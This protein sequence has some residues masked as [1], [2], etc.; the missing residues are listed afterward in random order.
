MLLSDDVDLSY[1]FGAF[2]QR[3]GRRPSYLLDSRKVAGLVRL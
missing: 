3:R 2:C 1:A